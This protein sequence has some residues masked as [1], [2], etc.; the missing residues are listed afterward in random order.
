MVLY[1]TSFGQH[2]KGRDMKISVIIPVYNTSQYLKKCISSVLEQTYANLEVLIVDDGS[3]DDSP[4]ICDSFRDFDSRVRVIHQINAGV[5]AARNTGLSLATGDLITFLDSDDYLEN[6]MYEL[7]TKTLVKYNADIVHCGYKRVDE[8]G[9]IIKEVFGSHR[10]VSQSNCEAVSYLLQGR[11]FTCSLCN[12][13]FSSRVLRDLKFDETLKINEDYH[14]VF[15]AFQKAKKV[16]FIDET[17]YRYVVQE[18]SAC[19]TTPTKG[20]MLNTVSAATL[21]VRDC[22]YKEIEPLVKKRLFTCYICFYRWMVFN[23]AKNKKELYSKREILKKLYKDTHNLTI[24]EKLNYYSLLYFFR[25]YRII[26]RAY[27]KIRKPN[28]DVNDG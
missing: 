28:W 2:G 4:Q 12:K 3:I 6:N 14:F 8:K 10:V 21:M 15:N 22:Q 23:E 27:D 19:N 24:K 20:K 1:N 11:L 16:V 17:L 9:N 13:L 7:L 5:S 26:Y 18:S 25:V